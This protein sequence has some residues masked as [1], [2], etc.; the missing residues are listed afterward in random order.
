[1]CTQQGHGQSGSKLSHIAEV[2]PDEAADRH[3]TPEPA[4]H[5]ADGIWVCMLRWQ[6]EHSEWL[7]AKYYSREYPAGR[8]RSIVVGRLSR[9]APSGRIT[10]LTKPCVALSLVA[11]ANQFTCR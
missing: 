1:M 2:A 7:M 10:V 5:V 4:G 11:V 3:T 6:S 8:P 9:G